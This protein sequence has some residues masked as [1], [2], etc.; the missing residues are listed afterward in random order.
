MHNTH[1]DT[2]G[3][4]YVDL[5]ILLYL[6]Y[7]KTKQSQSCYYLGMYECYINSPSRQTR[8]IIGPLQ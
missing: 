3:V 7:V 4:L 5:C 8:C 1:R 6:N 2:N